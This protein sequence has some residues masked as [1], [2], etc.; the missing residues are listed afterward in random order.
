MAQQKGRKI[1]VTI[2][3]DDVL[4]FGADVLA[5]KY[6]QAL[7]GVDAAVFS[8]IFAGSGN[9]KHLLPSPRQYK[10]V[11][12]GGRI[13]TGAVLFVGV[14]SLRRFGYKEIREFAQRALATLGELVPEARHVALTVHGPG[15][16]LD[17]AEA[18]ESEIAGLF[19]A[20]AGGTFPTGLE[21]ITIVEIDRGRAARLGK[22]L[23]RMLPDGTMNAIREAARFDSTL[24]ERLRTG[25]SASMAKPH[26]FVAMPFD[27]DM[28]DVFHYGIQGAVNAAGYL[29]ERADISSFTGDIVEWIKERIMTAAL[30]I[31]DLS[32]ANANVYL[33]VGFAWGRN[34]PTLLLVRD[35]GDLKFDVKGHRCIVYKKIKDLEDAL[36]KEL[37]QLKGH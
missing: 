5:V 1:A 13:K 26:V 31:A 22:T 2:E 17:E 12:S 25:G 18:F 23:S 37:A 9:V 11:E 29:C 27:E 35:L 3:V 36:R 24:P 21:R 20:V 34:K 33:E 8:R 15:Y 4:T 7:Y 14:E 28:D 19:D 32:T 16:G 10:L 6:A 30:V